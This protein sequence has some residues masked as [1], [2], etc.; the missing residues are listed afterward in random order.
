MTDLKKRRFG[1]FSSNPPT[2]THYERLQAHAVFTLNQLREKSQQIRTEK[3]PFGNQI[4]L[5]P[6]IRLSKCVAFYQYDT[7]QHISLVKDT[8]QKDTKI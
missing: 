3:P 4:P 2:T 1:F 7:T 5:L 8:T 6:L